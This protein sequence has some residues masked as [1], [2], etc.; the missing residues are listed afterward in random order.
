MI[1]IWN[2]KAD[3]GRRRRQWLAAIGMICVGMTVHAQSPAETNRPAAERLLELSRPLVI[4]HRG[5]PQLAPENTLP[6]F[7]FALVAGADLVELDYHHSQEGVPIVIHDATLDRTTDAVERWG[8]AK[9]E[10][11]SKTVTELRQLDAGKWFQPEFQGLRLPL[12]T[13]ALNVIQK[14]GVTLIERKAGDAATCARLLRERDLINRVVV[15]A[16]DWAYLRDFHREEPR[17]ILG[18]LGPPA[19]AK[20]LKDEEKE[21]SPRWV[22]EAAEAGARVVVWNR[23][24]RREAIEHAHQRKLKVWVYTINEPA[25]AEQLLALGVDGIITDNVSLIWRTLALQR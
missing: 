5:Y 22:D 16:F 15:Q 20:D 24:V 4:G 25:L 10:V 6:S 9:I 17:Q 2:R 1:T 8:S 21:L 12:L 11:G 14:G 23:R 18:A 7:R 13:E 19:H 3:N